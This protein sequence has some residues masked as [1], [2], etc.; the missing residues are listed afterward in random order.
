[1]QV[2]EL[3]NGLKALPLWSVGY[4]RCDSSQALKMLV[5]LGFDLFSAIATESSKATMLVPERG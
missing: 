5:W 1:M 4:Y 3:I 2:G